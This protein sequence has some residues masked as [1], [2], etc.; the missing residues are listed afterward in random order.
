VLFIIIQM[1]ATAAL[2]LGHFFI[3]VRNQ[4]TRTR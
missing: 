4:L 1:A 2:L 3:V